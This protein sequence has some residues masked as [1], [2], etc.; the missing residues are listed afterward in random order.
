MKRVSTL[1]VVLSLCLSA[2]NAVAQPSAATAD[3]PKTPFAYPVAPDTC[4]T[5]ESRCNYIVQ[6]FWNNYDI[7]KPIANDADFE[8]AFRDYVGFFRYAHKNIVMS[9]V[10]H[11][12]FKARSNSSNLVKV[13]RVAE[14]AL[15]GP[16][17]EYWSD[18]LY[19][20]IAKLISESTTLKAAERNYYKHQ[21]EV[22]NNCLVGAKLQ[23][24][25]LN[26]ATGKV[27]LSSLGAKSYL[28][29]FTDDSSSSSIDRLRLS[30]DVNLNALI[31]GG[32]LTAV[33]I[34]MGKAANGW[35][36]TQPAN[37]TNAYNE[38]VA[39]TLD[40]RGCPVCYI[41][42]SDLTILTKNVSA[43]DIKTALGQ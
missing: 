27:K 41:V 43:E 25:D 32:Q 10:R 4:A 21:I 42:D 5:L 33:Q 24:I 23:D 3:A 39:R 13:G 16:Y 12:I 34:F 11:F 9:S 36:E 18:E 15:Y 29:V 2:I 20:E 14:S 17:A 37:W 38:Q 8:T 1:F 6:N 35:A 28:L 22:I 40:L 26:T 19:V 7:A 31:E 30:T